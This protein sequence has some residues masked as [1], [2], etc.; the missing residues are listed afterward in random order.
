MEARLRALGPGDLER[1]DRFKAFDWVFYLPPK[2]AFD[3]VLDDI[4]AAALKKE[5]LGFFARTAVKGVLLALKPKIRRAIEGMRQG[6][7]FRTVVQAQTPYG[8]REIS[9][10]ADA[11]VEVL[12]PF[13]D[14]DKTPPGRT[15]HERA[16][17]AV[18]AQLHKNE[19][20]RTA[21]SV[22]HG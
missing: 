20:T 3:R 17:N 5:E 9:A 13:A 16:V 1:R 19:E 4:I 22:S 18:R 11:Y 6:M 7:M 14:K 21:E 12:M 2:G 10:L 8:K 15:E